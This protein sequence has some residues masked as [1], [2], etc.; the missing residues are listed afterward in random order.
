[1]AHRYT[2]EA[3]YEDRGKQQWDLRFGIWWLTG[4]TRTAIRIL[5]DREKRGFY[6]WEIVLE[7]KRHCK[8]A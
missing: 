5:S 8:V 4:P 7:T 2:S 1:M 3:E 6:L